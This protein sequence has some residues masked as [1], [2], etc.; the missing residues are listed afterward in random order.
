MPLMIAITTK[1]FT[2]VIVASDNAAVGLPGGSPALCATAARSDG[3]DRC[4]IVLRT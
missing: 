1:H 2:T 3:K 4:A